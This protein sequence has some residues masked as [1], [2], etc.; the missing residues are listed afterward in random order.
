MRFTLTLI[1]VV[2]LVDIAIAADFTDQD[3][4]RLFKQSKAKPSELF[5]IYNWSPHMNLS[6]MGLL[7]LK[8][9]TNL[10]V[11]LDPSANDAM[12]KKSAQK[13][14][15]DST[16]LLRNRSEELRKLGTLTHYPSYAFIKNGKFAAGLLPGY[17]SDTALNRFIAQAIEK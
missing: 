7:N 12:A 1:F 8:T 9:R 5:I 11:L 2:N 15:F 17:K 6:M 16:I 3:L 13:L 10:T 14:K 4:E